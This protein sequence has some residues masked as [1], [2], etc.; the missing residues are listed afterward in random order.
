[1]A[2]LISEG[3]SGCL[4][5]MTNDQ[6]R[7][8]AR[9]HDGRS[10]AEQ[11]ARQRRGRHGARP[12]KGVQLQLSQPPDGATQSRQEIRGGSSTCSVSCKVP[13]LSSATTRGDI[14]KRIRTTDVTAQ[15]VGI[16]V[17]DG[18][19]EQGLRR[20]PGGRAETPRRAR[21]VL[22][23]ARGPQ[24]VT[25]IV[26][27]SGSI[28]QKVE[29]NRVNVTQ[30]P[31]GENGSRLRARLAAEKQ[32]LPILGND[33]ETANRHTSNTSSGFRLHRAA[34]RALGQGI[35]PALRA[36]VGRSIRLHRPHGHQA[37]RVH[38]HK[39]SA[40]VA[41]FGVSKLSVTHRS[42]SRMLP[43]GARNARYGVTR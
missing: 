30:G 36:G 2:K 5:R 10:G 27:I 43:S 33:D 3:Y 37:G 38:R 8:A 35:R 31:A 18:W 12:H 4:I 28:D 15:V 20:T 32:Q 24:L 40:A 19:I 26:D 42:L 1:M 22:L 14:T 23:C 29:A 39:R 41:A 25:R 7:R 21:K 34:R 13:T 11:R 9:C 17:L 6:R 16:R